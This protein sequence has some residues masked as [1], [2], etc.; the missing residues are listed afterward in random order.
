MNKVLVLISM[1][2]MVW[3]CKESEPPID[4][5]KPGT[6]LLSQGHNVLASSEVPAAD[7]RGI[8]IEDLTGVRCVACPNAAK[9]AKSIKENEGNN[10]VVI[11]GLYTTDPKSLTF[12][13]TNF[14]DI[15]TETAQ[16]IGA[17][18]YN[19]SNTLPAGGVNRKV[20]SGESSEKIPYAV[21]NNKA[22]SFS[23][24]KA[25][26]N[27]A[28]EQNKKD[29]STYVF[30]CTSVFT[31]TPEETPFLTLFLVEDDI[32]HPQKNTSGTDSSYI[33]NHVVRYAITPYNGM[34]LTV[35]NSEAIQEGSE[36]EVVWQVQIPEN[37]DM[38]KAG[39]VAFINYNA[40]SNKEVIQ[41]RDIHLK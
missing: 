39:L 36:I 7:Y 26:V 37:I 13:F 20:F 14:E 12:P 23:D 27:L 21:W 22:S 34:P 4:F 19:F 30:T 5:G 10:P 2:I 1:A 29:D 41:C 8:L 3:S 32:L 35:E 33:H 28:I 25:I 6:I 18:I 31:S 16:L 40:E 24:E 11:L 15:R 9:E 17:N 38:S